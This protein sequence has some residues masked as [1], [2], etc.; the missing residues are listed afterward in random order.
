MA[1]TMAI[2]SP[3][4]ATVLVFVVISTRA[5]GLLVAPED[6]RVT[7]MVVGIGGAMSSALVVALRA[8]VVV[9]RRLAVV[10]A[11]LAAVEV[12]LAAVEVAVRALV[13]L[14]PLLVRRP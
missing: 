4:V 2:A 8:V 10:A 11:V 5:V 1:T 9:C 13:P 6:R 7:E 12:P 14:L 3:A